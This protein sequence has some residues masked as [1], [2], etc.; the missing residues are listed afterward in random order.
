MILHS[1]SGYCKLITNHIC[2]K[3]RFIVEYDNAYHINDNAY[4]MILITTVLKRVTY[5][6]KNLLLS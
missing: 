3:F 4:I 2:S 1:S 6:K 5:K